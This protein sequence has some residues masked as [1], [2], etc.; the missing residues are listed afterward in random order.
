MQRV[1][2]LVHLVAI[3]ILTIASAGAFGPTRRA[4]YD[5]VAVSGEYAS[6]SHQWQDGTDGI[7]RDVVEADVDDDNDGDA[8]AHAR[9]EPAI[10]PHRS[11]SPRE[12]ERAKR[13]DLPSDT[14]RFAIRESLA[15][16]PPTI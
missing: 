3:A 12:T 10:D 11:L 14:S 8:P 6:R 7:Y 13:A 2:W 1:M 9:A 15:R 5:R 16:G 4:S